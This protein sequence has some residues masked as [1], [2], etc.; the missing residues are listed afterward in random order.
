MRLPHDSQVCNHK[1]SPGALFIFRVFD[2][3]QKVYS[4][5]A[6]SQ[7]ELSV[8]TRYCGS[9]TRVRRGGVRV[10]KNNSDRWEGRKEVGAY[11][12]FDIIFGSHVR[13]IASEHKFSVSPK[14][15]FHSFSPS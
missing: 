9:C 10:R 1:A 15:A 12:E 8:L 14:S 2:R 5:L 7:S 11:F 4:S 3:V 6:V 13:R